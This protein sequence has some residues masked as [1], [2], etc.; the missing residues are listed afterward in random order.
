M[1]KP[2]LAGIANHLRFSPSVIHSVGS[3]WSVFNNVYRGSGVMEE[4]LKVPNSCKCLVRPKILGGLLR[5]VI[6]LG[7]H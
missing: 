6:K 5:G 7:F 4:K 1:L 2:E 3:G